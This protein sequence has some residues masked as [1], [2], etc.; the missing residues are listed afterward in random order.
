MAISSYPKISIITPCYNSEKYLENTIISVLDQNY[1]NLEYIV[2]DG[3]SQDNTIEIIRKYEN[4]L[5]FWISEEDSGLY[6]ALNK[7]FKKTTGEIMGWIGSDD[8]YHKNSFFVIA[9]IFSEHKTIQW[10][11]G[12][13]TAF[14]EKGRTVIVS[15]SRK[16]TRHDFLNGD[17]KWLQQESCLWKRDLWE[18]AGGT[19]NEEMRYAG[20]FELW[21]RFFRFE[22][23]YVTD[24]LIGGFRQRSSDQ[25]SLNFGDDYLSEAQGIINREKALTWKGA[26]KHTEHVIYFDRNKQ[27]FL[28][29]EER[30][31]IIIKNRFLTMCKRALKRILH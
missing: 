26:K 14:D 28:L 8:M 13:Q 5:A 7:G 21:I 24:A 18:K 25:L 1:P 20:D 27:K 30:K 23:L 4:Q 11:V 12:A 3:G 6:D 19:L 22:K 17:F 29:K 15:R 31:L 9:E 2:I 16:F 10:L